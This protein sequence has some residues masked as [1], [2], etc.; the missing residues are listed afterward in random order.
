MTLYKKNRGNYELCLQ[1]NNEIIYF[2]PLLI[3]TATFVNIHKKNE[4]VHQGGELF[5]YNK[6]SH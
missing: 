6:N 1:I 4:H 5:L 2:L 3:N